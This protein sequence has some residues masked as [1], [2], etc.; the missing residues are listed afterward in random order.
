MIERLEKE[1]DY[2]LVD[3]P[4]VL[5]I[6]DAKA[7]SRII[8]N[9]LLV[10]RFARTEKALCARGGGNLLN[11]KASIIGSSLTASRSATARAI[12]STITIPNTGKVRCARVD[13]VQVN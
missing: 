9:M 4:P 8:E 11:I 13:K 1:Y 6:S 2:V 7:L 5:S 12:T 10:F 3:A